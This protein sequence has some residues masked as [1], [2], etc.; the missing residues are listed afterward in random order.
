MSLSWD[1]TGQKQNAS[2][3]K[4]C[5]QFLG[6]LAANV[7]WAVPAW[8]GHVAEVL[9][10]VWQQ[11]FGP[12]VVGLSG[13]LADR[14]ECCYSSPVSWWQMRAPTASW[15]SSWRAS[16]FGGDGKVERT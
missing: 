7:V 8:Y 3:D 10:Q 2:V 15:L 11:N 1:S 14:L 5:I 12:V 13:P 4:A 6:G 9:I 16:E